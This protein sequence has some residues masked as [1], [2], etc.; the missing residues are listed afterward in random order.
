MSTTYAPSARGDLKGFAEP[1]LNSCK[2]QSG[3]KIQIGD[4]THVEVGILGASGS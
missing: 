4:E 1:L 2:I 3:K